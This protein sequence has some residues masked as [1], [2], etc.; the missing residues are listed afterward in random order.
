MADATCADTTHTASERKQQK[1]NPTQSIPTL[2]ASFYLRSSR[3]LRSLL[4]SQATKSTSPSSS[5]SSDQSPQ[6]SCPRTSHRSN[7]DSPA[8]NRREPEKNLIV[9]QNSLLPCANLLQTQAYR[10]RQAWHSPGRHVMDCAT[11][12]MFERTQASLVRAEL[13]LRLYVCT[14]RLERCLGLLGTIV[15]ACF[16]PRILRPQFCPQSLSLSL[17]LALSATSSPLPYLLGVQIFVP[18]C[19]L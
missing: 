12:A 8:T 18:S 13:V 7:T 4:Q 5:Q 17:S 3:T 10:I 19:I 15:S 9:I 11:P 6:S 14:H 2:G 1:P 16:R